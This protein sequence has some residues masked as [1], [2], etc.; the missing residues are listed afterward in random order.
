MKVNHS[1]YI[2]FNNGEYTVYIKTLTDFYA[3]SDPGFVEGLDNGYEINAVSNEDV[4]ITN[5]TEFVKFKV[6]VKGYKYYTKYEN[7]GSKIASRNVTV[8]ASYKY[9]DEKK[10]SIT[11]ST[12]TQNVCNKEH[13]MDVKTL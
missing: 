7:N 12:K 13:Y 5:T 9:N 3:N 10:T 8:T 2:L 4:T 1:V 6:V 11:T